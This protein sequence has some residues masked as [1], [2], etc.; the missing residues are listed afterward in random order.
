MEP[1]R[2]LPERIASEDIDRLRRIAPDATLDSSA[3]INEFANLMQEYRAAIRAVRT[4]FEIL[5]EDAKV[6][7][8]RNPIHAI[9]TRLKS[10]Q[11]LFEKL[12][13]RGL[14][15]TIESIRTNIHDVAGVRVVCNYLDDVNEVADALL[16]QDDVTL[17][18]RKDYIAEPKPSGYRSLHL[19]VSV[20]VFLSDRK[21][22]VA[23]EVQLRTI[24]MDFWASL[25]HRLRYKNDDVLQ[26]HG[27]EIDD[28][29]A[30]LVESAHLIAAI[31][32]AMQRL[33]DDIEALAGEQGAS[34]RE[35]PDRDA[36]ARLA[37]AKAQ[38]PADPQAGA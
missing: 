37:N 5:D 28:I 13:R 23:V 30:R 4:K 7:L 29:R 25:E 26:A 36:L 32:Q 19:V 33:Q 10:P 18:Q 27:P 35:I 11:S 6:R 9:S 14:P 24:A 16:R 31:D 38:V 1:E 8:D 3:F 12:E 17:I 22:E 15:A 2:P 34:G 20:P 21:R